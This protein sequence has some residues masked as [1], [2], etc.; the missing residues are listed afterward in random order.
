[1]FVHPWQFE[2]A[3]RAIEAKEIQL[4]KFHVVVSSSL[5]SD[6][7]SALS[8]LSCRQG[9]RVRRRHALTDASAQCPSDAPD[10]MGHADANNEAR[11]GNHEDSSL[12]L[13]VRRTLICETRRL[14]SPEPV[15]QST[16]EAHQGCENP[17]RLLPMSAS[18]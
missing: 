11:L 15:A 5:E 16:T 14:R 17:R 3:T 13:E 7:E 8:D 4:R 2:V 1:M 10:A 12:P 18:D 6:V 9:A